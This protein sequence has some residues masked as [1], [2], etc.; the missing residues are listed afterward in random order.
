MSRQIIGIDYSF[1]SPAIC[2]L[3]EDFL[4]SQFYFCTEKKKQALSFKN[5]KGT[6]MEKDWAN[7][8]E[9]YSRLARWATEIIKQF[10]DPLVALEGYAYGSRAGLLFNIAENAGI[11]KHLLWQEGIQPEIVSPTEVKKFWFGKGNAKKENMN[12]ALISKEGVDII[13]Y[14]VMNK[15]DNPASDVVDAYA[16]ARW[17]NE[18]CSR[19]K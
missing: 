19:G 10:D 2:V 18:N 16:I 12:E 1:T 9:R 17:A 6:L 5:I 13:S 11:L 3:G 15:M 7:S 4:S 8:I 14:M